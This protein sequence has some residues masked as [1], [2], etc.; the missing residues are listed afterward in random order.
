MNRVNLAPVKLVK[1][2]ERLSMQE[3]RE[4]IPE[5]VRMIGAPE[6]WE[7]ENKGQGVVI[8]VLDSGCDTRHPDLQD[9]IIGGHN[10]TIEGENDQDYSDYHWHGTHVAGTIAAN[11]N[12]KGLIG[13]AP[14][15]NLLILKVLM[16]HN[17]DKQGGSV[18]FVNWITEAIRYAIAWRGPNGEKVRIISMSIINES[19]ENEEILAM[20]HAIQDAIKENIIV[21]ACAGNASKDCGPEGDER[22]YPGFFPEV[23]SV[24]SVN[25][26]KT[27]PCRS[28]NSQ[29][30]LA[31]PGENIISTIPGGETAT[32]SG[33]S[34]A[35]PH[36]AGA[37]ALIINQCE[38]EFG[39]KLTEAEIYA[40]I[41]KRTV[42]LGY[43]KRIEGNGLL[44][45]SKE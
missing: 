7:K 23:V 45:L 39:R 17:C 29:I 43:D 33:C 13:V 44:L 24:A 18:G 34:M 22:S 31:A 9:R 6:M 25:L 12:G 36:V 2:E 37:T 16:L 28:T 40:Q 19:E 20:H 11:H 30:D 14:E 35:V 1:R 3:T 42:S 8:A 5:G 15:A 41:I 21:I 10:F 38:K 26:D 32:A 4:I 27:F